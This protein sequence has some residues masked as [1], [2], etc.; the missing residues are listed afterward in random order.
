[1]SQTEYFPWFKADFGQ[2]MIVGSVKITQLGANFTGTTKNVIAIAVNKVYS[3][4]YNNFLH[5][6]HFKMK[7]SPTNLGVLRPVVNL[8]RATAGMV[9]GRSLAKKR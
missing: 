3:C 9:S 8:W 7:M 1:M 5:S 2:D 4:S 6:S